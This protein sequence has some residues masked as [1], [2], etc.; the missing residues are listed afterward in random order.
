MAKSRKRKTV[1]VTVTLSV[2]PHVTAAQARRELRKRVNQK[3]GYYSWFG[4][5]NNAQP[6]KDSD[7]RVRKV[8]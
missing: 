5:G 2:A 3:C 6:A 8:D 4:E 1:K 7:V